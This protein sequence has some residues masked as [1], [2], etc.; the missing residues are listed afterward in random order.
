MESLEPGEQPETL[1]KWC[2]RRQ[3]EVPHFKFWYTAFQLE[4]LVLIYVKSLRTADFPLYIDCLM[5]LAPWFFCLDHTNYA[6]WLP[7]H[8]Q[9]M[10]NLNNTHP[11][12]ASEFNDGKFTVHK[13]RRVFSSMALDHAHEQNNAAVKSDG[14]AISLTQNPEALRRWMVAGPELV[15]I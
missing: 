10:V 3:Q 2:E 6:R 12:I 1:E 11:K 13:T 8:I 7:V 15:R 9:D 14:G 4:L 5:Q